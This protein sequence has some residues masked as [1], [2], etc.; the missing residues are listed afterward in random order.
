MQIQLGCS[1]SFIP[2][3][4]KVSIYIY[5]TPL[6]TVTAI[7]IDH[8]AASVITEIPMHQTPKIICKVMFSKHKYPAED[9]KSHNS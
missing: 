7:R 6:G 2:E 9:L 5:H 3:A 4:T 1:N 8:S